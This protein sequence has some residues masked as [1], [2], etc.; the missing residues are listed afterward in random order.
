MRRT[1]MLCRSCIN[2]EYK[3]VYRIEKIVNLDFIEVSG[4]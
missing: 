4:G 3:Y 1:Y 2:N